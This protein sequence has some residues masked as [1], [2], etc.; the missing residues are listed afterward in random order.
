M[1]ITPALEWEQNRQSVDDYTQLMLHRDGKFYHVYNQS[2]WLLKMFM[3]TEEYQKRRGDDKMLSVSRYKTKNN[4][5]V[6]LG[7]PIESLSK[8]LV[9]YSTANQ[10]GKGDN[11]V[12]IDNPFGPDATIEQIQA[13][14]E[15]WMMS[16]PLKESNAQKRRDITGNSEVAALS[17]SGLFHTMMQVLSYPVENRT[18]AQNVE[19]ISELKRQLIQLL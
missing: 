15:A 11:L 2:A 4:E 6:M 18:P 17:H 7:F 10:D 8:F 9:N 16:I 19:F 3:C 12:M 14:Y 1:R 5:Y 13:D